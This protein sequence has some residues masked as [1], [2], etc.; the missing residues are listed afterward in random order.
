MHSSDYSEQFSSFK[1][2]H[3]YVLQNINQPSL[4]TLHTLKLLILLFQIMIY[5]L[6]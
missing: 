5:V 4:G 2:C 6:F 3:L 1:L